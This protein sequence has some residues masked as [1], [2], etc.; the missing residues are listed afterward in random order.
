LVIPNGAF[1]REKSACRLPQE[2]R[3]PDNHRM[4]KSDWQRRIQR[5]QELIEQHAVAAEMLGF[6]VHLARL[7]E[8]LHRD[9]ER[10]IEKPTPISAGSISEHDL[11]TL[12]SKF[13]AYLSVVEKHG[14]KLL[15][16]LARDLQ[17]P[18]KNNWAE[19]LQDAWRVRRPCGAQEF[20]VQAFLQPYAELLRSRIS[21][22]AAESRYAICPFCQRKPSVGV[23]RPMGEGAAR[24]LVC[25]FCAVEWNF[26][27]LVCP[28][29]GEEN[30]KNLLV[31]T[32]SDFDYIRVEGC[33]TCKTY[34]KTI[35]L[36][37]NG[38]GEPL[39]DELASA[40]LDVWAREQGYAKLQP[41]LLGM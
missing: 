13:G 39:V 31:F 27:R 29:C 24:S 3:A 21:L 32:A 12:A 11:R 36:T 6:Y 1:G 16:R 5:A 30:D 34:I 26:R 14:P 20:L 22:P 2:T 9:L 23:L 4:P 35:D 28:G 10:G 19:L 7:Q 41:N 33:E 40:S 18:G 17:T 25:G 8:Q 38:H 37:K 15:S